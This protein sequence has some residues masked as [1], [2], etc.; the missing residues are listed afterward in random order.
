VRKASA[1]PVHT[2]SPIAKGAKSY[3]HR[4]TEIATG[5]TWHT[6]EALLKPWF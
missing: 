3:G 1:I 2:R 5:A 4:G 6:G